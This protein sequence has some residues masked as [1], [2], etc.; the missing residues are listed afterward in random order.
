MSRRYRMRVWIC[1]SLGFR[2]L[3]FFAVT[4]VVGADVTIVENGVAKAAIHVSASVLSETN[5]DEQKLHDTV[6]DMAGILE[7]MTGAKV[8][9]VAGAPTPNA[10]ALPIL[11][12]DLATARF[13]PPKTTSAFKQAWRR[14][15]TPTGVGFI[16]ESS[17]AVTY[18][19]YDLFDQLG[20][21]WYMPSEL[22]EILS[23]VKTLR[24]LE[25]DVSE[26]PRLIGRDIWYADEVFK[27]RNR[28]GGLSVASVH[29][30]E[31]YLTGSDAA[32]LKEHP[33]WNGE[34]GGK[35]EINGAICWGNSEAAKAIADIIIADREKTGVKT[36]TLTPRDAIT[37]CECAKCKAL[38]TGDWDDNF[39]TISIS[40][41]FVHFINP[42][43]E[44]VTKRYPD[45]LLGTCAYEQYT[46]PPL[47]EKLHPNIVMKIAPILFCRAHSF[48]STQCSSRQSLKYVV[49][50]WGK[51]TDKLTFRDYGYNLAEVSAPFPLISKWSDELPFLYSHNMAIWHPETMPTFEGT[52]PGFVIG[53]RLAWHADLKP[54]EILDEFYTRFYG[55]AAG[56]MREYWQTCDDAW[57]KVPEHAGC[58]FGHSRRFT[59]EVLGAARKAMDKAIAAAGTDTEKKRVGIASESL[60]AFELFMKIRRDLN[61]GRLAQ[62]AQNNQTWLANWQAL[63]KEYE[64]QC[65]FSFFNARYF[66]RLFRLTSDDACRI[67]TSGVV[68][69]KPLREWQLAVDG[70]R[71]GEKLG[72]QN[73]DFDDSGWKKTD[74]C[75]DT[76]AALGIWN[77]TGL[78]VW[79]RS[80]VKV[81]AVLGG[82]K[83]FLWIGATDGSVQVFVNG[84]HFPYVNDNGESLPEFAGYAQPASFEVTQA[85]HLDSENTLAIIGTRTGLNELGTGGL[86]GPAF[87]YREK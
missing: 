61:E 81:P 4:S 35:R 38:D 31:H 39:N 25:S 75:V 29:G 66:N 40:D 8:P 76:W 79:Y 3:G 57:T 55:P 51:A 14:V 74:S 17:E 1:Q 34:V 33:E 86:L 32:P 56:P 85:I 7:R 12:G 84:R 43:A 13:G 64:P 10:A 18:A 59:P 62:L 69:S 2:A 53:I 50:G 80:K 70:E 60:K 30:L 21:R 36:H 78:P 24:L 77:K 46:R 11:I 22:G 49:E 47:R 16:G 9:V 20:C 15:V 72:W 52:L 71:M 42:I 27:R 82:K 26:T 58:G 6:R 41:R 45:E 19:V 28:L 65:A 73:P 67:A 87:L 44:I 23:A 68:I 54:P 48:L 5:A 37:F 83:V 63:I